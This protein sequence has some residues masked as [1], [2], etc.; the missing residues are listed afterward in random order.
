MS[1]EVAYAVKH[2]PCIAVNT[3][4]KLAPWAWALYADQP[5]WEKYPSID[6]SGLRIACLPVR[7]VHQ[8][9]IAGSVGYTDDADAVHTYGN[10]GAQ[11][12]QIAVKSGAS[13]VLLCGFD[14]HGTH[15][16][17]EYKDGLRNTPQDRYR[18]WVDD[19]RHL[20]VA[21]KTRADVVNVTPG[22]ALVG[23]RKSTL[24]AELAST[25]PATA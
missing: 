9:R 22:S 13:K 21:L 24:E 4:V 20:A 6:F 5:W 16:H 23:F 10:S 8:L 15:W 7:G 12:I 17:G 2:L 18:I 3:T 14:M 25:Q 19:M 11:A 1:Q